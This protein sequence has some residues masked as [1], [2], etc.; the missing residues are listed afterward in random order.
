[1]LRPSKKITR[2]ELKE[3]KLVSTYS[4]MTAFYEQNKRTINIAVLVVA[5]AIVAV[6]VYVRN[7]E[8][9]SEKAHAALGAISS[10]IDNGQYQTAIDGVPSRNIQGL[11]AI[12]ENFGNSPGGE[13]A[14]FQLASSLLA[15]GKYDE[16]L[17]H[18]K[19]FSPPSALLDAG[20]R[21]GL[22]TCYEALKEYED[23][24][25][26]FEKAAAV[27]ATD[28]RVP[29][30]LHNAARNY[31]AAGEKE[32]AVELWKRLKKTHPA[33]AYGRDAERYIVQY[34]L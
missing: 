34:S 4:S 2:K 32:Q 15:L 29:E 31:A 22:G 8:D 20:R 28:P 26:E 7:R 30:F 6:V 18:Y 9:A 33:S 19:D 10:Y 12:V 23:A 27:D 3:D 21:A 25:S 11:R 5:M 13:L 1:M 14:R 16:A 17:Q 24:A